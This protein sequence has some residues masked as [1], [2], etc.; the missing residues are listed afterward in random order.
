L[1]AAFRRDR[2]TKADAISLALF[3]DGAA[4][5]ALRADGEEGGLHFC[6]GFTLLNACI[7]YQR[8]RTENAALAR[9]AETGPKAQ[10]LANESR[11]L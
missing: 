3:G 10:T 11:S 1:Y 7:L 4:V 5:A 9:A 2:I 8:V 6:R